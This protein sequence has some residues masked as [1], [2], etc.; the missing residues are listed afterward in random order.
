[1][2]IVA[3][4]KELDS[5]LLGEVKWSEKKVGIDIYERLKQKAGKVKWGSKARKEFFCLF[6]KKGFTDAMLKKAEDEGVL[7]FRENRLL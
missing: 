1:M 5:I 2:D 7:L 3:I 4:N 6:S